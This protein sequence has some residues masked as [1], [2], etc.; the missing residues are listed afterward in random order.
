MPIKASP[1]SYESAPSMHL[2]SMKPL[3]CSNGGMLS[4]AE[5]PA[6]MPAQGN[7]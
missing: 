5:A 3:P 7:K 1:V 4:G 2:H 6:M